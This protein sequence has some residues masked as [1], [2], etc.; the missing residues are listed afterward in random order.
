M[1]RKL[2]TEQ[3]LERFRNKHGDRYNYSLDDF[4]TVEDKITIICKV[5][6]E[7]PQIPKKHYNGHGCSKCSGNYK[8]TQEQFLEKAVSIYGDR[9]DYS[10]V[11]FTYMKDYVTIIC[12]KHGPFE[13]LAK[14]F[15]LGKG[16]L[17][18]TN[19]QKSLNNRKS[20]EKFIEDAKKIHGEKYDYSLVEYINSQTNIK[21]VCSKHGIFNQNPNNH[22]KGSIC[23]ICSNEEKAINQT[24]PKEY[25]IEKVK[26]IHNNKYNYDGIDYINLKTKIDITCLKHGK[27]CQLPENHLIGRGCP[28]CKQSKGEKLVSRFLEENSI[29]FTVQKIFEGCVHKSHLKFDFYIPEHNLAIEY[30]GIQHFKPIEFFGGEDALKQLQKRDVIKDNY[31]SKNNID[32]LRIKYDDKFP[33]KILQ[34]KLFFQLVNNPIP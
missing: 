2:T 13:R 28:K 11:N 8:K 5:H 23:K 3:L 31:C 25:F 1:P 30:D 4:K 10:S 20:L 27:F 19:E 18:C 12:E 16:C 22:L 17:D 32:L 26:Q 9:Y 15:V 21:I 7:F 34:T 6:G 24:Y 14:S 29:D 33:E